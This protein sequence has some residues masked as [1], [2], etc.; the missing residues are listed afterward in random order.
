[1]SPNLKQIREPIQEEMKT[2]EKQFH[3]A[4]KSK[5]PLLDRVMRFLVKRKGKQVRPLFVFLTAGTTGGIQPS[6]Y[7]GAVLM[8]L[9]HTATLVHDDVVDDAY[10]R[11]GFFSINALWKNKIAVLAGDYLLSRSL[12]HSLE[13]DDFL[14]LKKASEAIKLMSEGELLQIE[15]ARSLNVNEDLYFDIIRRKTASLI[16]SSCAIGAFSNNCSEEEIE[17]MRTFGEKAGIAFQIKDD[18]LDFGDNK[19]GKPAL[20]DI[21]EKKV[22]LPMI[23]TLQNTGKKERKSIISTLKKHN[24]NR[25]KVDE[26]IE[27][28]YQTGG[29]EYARNLMYQYRDEAFALIENF[30]ENTYK[31]SLKDLVNFSINRDR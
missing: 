7:R 14:M 25:Q 15:K 12:L 1:M 10:Q 19:S 8:E 3:E 2:F 26:V 11:R 18:L 24:K 30:E 4:L 16:A 13:N 6:T 23:Y 5:V 31:A 9:I 29:I 22:T 17:T 20:N 28:V 21:K 27:K